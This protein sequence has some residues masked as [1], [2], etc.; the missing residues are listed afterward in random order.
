M[1]AEM[2]QFFKRV[3]NL[4]LGL[5]SLLMGLI[6]LVLYAVAGVLWLIGA[7]FTLVRVAVA[8]TVLGGLG[9]FIYEYWPDNPPKRPT[10]QETK[11]K[12]AGETLRGRV[13]TLT[14]QSE[15]D[16]RREA[17]VARRAR[18]RYQ[19]EERRLIEQGRER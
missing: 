17:A 11:T 3:G 5:I 18:A 14:Q 15:A 8:L 10:Y 12:G 13:P 2:G 7:A 1:G 16:R 19:A 6:S 9:V 4:F